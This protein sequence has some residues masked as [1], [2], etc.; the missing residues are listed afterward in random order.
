MQ[1]LDCAFALPRSYHF[2]SVLAGLP[3]VARHQQHTILVPVSRLPE[4]VRQRSS[5][6]GAFD[7]PKTDTVPAD[8]RFQVQQREMNCQP[9]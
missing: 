5:T 8:E 4:H 2:N 7:V 1:R 9:S 6:S 3:A